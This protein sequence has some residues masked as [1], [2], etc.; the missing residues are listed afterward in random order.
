MK[1]FDLFGLPLDDIDAA[2]RVIETA[3]GISF[4]PHES[5]YMGE[6]YLWRQGEEK[7]LLRRNLDPQDGEVAE[8]R[9][10]HFPIL[11]DV[12][13]PTD[14]VATRAALAKVGLVLLERVELP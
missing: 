1:T 14:A 13:Q 4:V 3:L 6:Y 8:A 9:F 10:A 2:R 11:L 7:V 5:L 12:T